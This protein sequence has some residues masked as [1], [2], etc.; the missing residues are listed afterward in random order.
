M[1]NDAATSELTRRLLV[2]HPG[3]PRIGVHD[4]VHAAEGGDGLA[5]ETFHVELVGDVGAN[6]ERRAVRADDLVDGGFGPTLIVQ[7]H[8][9]NGAAPPGQCTSELATGYR[10]TA[11]DDHHGVGERNHSWIVDCFDAVPSQGD[12]GPLPWS[13]GFRPCL[14]AARLSCWAEPANAERL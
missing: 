12:P 8:H 3:G 14:G 10:R 11:G 2:D 9:D 13:I 5:E 1:D 7:V 6:R 4:D